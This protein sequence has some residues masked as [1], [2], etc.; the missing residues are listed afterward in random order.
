MAENKG[1]SAVRAM[2]RPRL[3]DGEPWQEHEL[4]PTP[5]WAT[6]ALFE[7]VLPA[8]WDKSYKADVIL[9]PA[10]GLG[11]MAAVL[12]EYCDNVFASDIYNYPMAD[13]RD[14]FATRIATHDFLSEDHECDVDWVITNPPFSLAHAFLARALTCA[15]RGVALLLRIQW[16]EGQDRYKD[17]FTPTPPSLIAPFVERVPMCE[18]GYDPNGSTAS[19]YAWFVWVKNLHGLL[20][21]PLTEGAT[22]PSLLIPPCKGELWRTSDRLLAARCVPG[23]I[24]PSRL[25]KVGKDQCALDFEGGDV[26]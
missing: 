19:M 4:F 5:P 18:G 12:D 10:A 8:V 17:V 26:A 25:K 6:R 16:M 14:A 2:K 22:I 23:F 7:H 13:G 1:H 15:S 20:P 24:P 9:E 21:A 11:H 3:S